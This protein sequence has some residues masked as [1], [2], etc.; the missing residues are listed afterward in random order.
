MTCERCGG[1]SGPYRMHPDP[2]ECCAR[3][4]TENARLAA[5]RD[6]AQK[7][8]KFMVDR[9]INEKLDGYRELGR[10]AADAE[11]A[12]D[13]ER[14]AHARTKAKL[15]DMQ[16]D[17]DRQSTRA[18]GNA[19]MV[20]E[21][22]RRMAELCGVLDAERE[23]HARTRAELAIEAK[24]ALLCNDALVAERV[25]IAD[26]EVERDHYR[27]VFANA[28]DQR[29]SAREKLAAANKRWEQL[30]EPLR[31][32]AV[33]NDHE[34]REKKVPMLINPHTVLAWMAAL[35]TKEGA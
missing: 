28:C 25:A 33:M 7:N 2:H 5:E 22:T 9:A 18:S 30:R 32:W 15:A 27:T 26:L 1:D 21:T 16:Y 12:L 19:E 3:L 31:Q 4:G 6:E 10:K 17:R 20:A 29:E 24:S 11:N 8:Y 13:R 34:R 35:E 14:E 23:A